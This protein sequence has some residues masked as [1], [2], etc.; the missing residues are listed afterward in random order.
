MLDLGLIQIEEKRT[1]GQAVKASAPVIPVIPGA[2]AEAENGAKILRFCES[3]RMLHWAIVVPFLVCYL[4][5]AI[6]VLY[7]NPNPLRP[8]RIF[9]AWFHR[10]SGV[11]LIIFPISALFRHRKQVPLHLY[12]IKHALTWVR[13]DFK[14]LSLILPA[15]FNDKIKLPGQGK[16]NAA[17]KIN[18]LVLLGTYPL[19]LVTGVCIWLKYFAVPSWFVHVIMAAIATPLIF[20]HMY[21]AVVNRGSRPGLQ[22]MFSGF[23][24]RHWAK[25]HYRHWY[26][27]L[28]EP[29]QK[30]QEV[31]EDGEAG[32]YL[33]DSG[34]DRSQDLRHR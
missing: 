10:I 27:E 30:L 21:M 2:F 33:C 24:D 28:Y 22:G 19:Y 1:G 4:T 15:A 5:A 12:N 11:C 7:Y 6:M 16:F 32:Q 23:V 13:D 26:R 17:E 18:F 8:Y 14:W 25:H 3:E 20:G 29:E 31:A 9:F 34:E